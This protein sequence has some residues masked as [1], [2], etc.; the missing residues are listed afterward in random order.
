MVDPAV[1]LRLWRQGWTSAQACSQCQ[2]ASRSKDEHDPPSRHCQ[3]HEPRPDWRDGR[4]HCKNGSCRARTACPVYPKSGD[5][6]ATPV[7]PKKVPTGNVDRHSAGAA[8]ASNFTLNKSDYQVRWAVQDPV[9]RWSP[10]QPIQVPR[11]RTP[12]SLPAPDA[13]LSCTATEARTAP[14]LVTLPLK[15]PTLGDVITPSSMLTG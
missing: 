15:V 6:Q 10:D 8:R 11:P 12:F 1:R 14:E 9:Q 5:R 7:S 4:A 13:C 2:M 3:Y